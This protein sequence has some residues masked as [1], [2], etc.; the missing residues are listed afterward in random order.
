MFSD[1]ALKI[2]SAVRTG[3]IKTNAHF[4]KKFCSVDRI[5]SIKITTIN[6]EMFLKEN[7]WN[8]VCFFDDNFPKLNINLKNSEKPFLFAYKG[9]I[10]LLNSPNNIAVIGTTTLTEEISKRETEIVKEFVKNDLCI[11]SGLAKGCDTIAHEECLKNNGK[12]IAFLPTTLK[13]IYPKENKKL[14]EEIIKSG[15]LVI[16]EYVTEPKNKY[17]NIK[18]FIDRD[19]LQ[20]LFSKAVILVAS[21]SQGNGDSGSRHAMNKAKEYEKKQFVMFNEKDDNNPL[22]QMNKEY[23]NLGAK[24][25]TKKTIKELK[26]ETSC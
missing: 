12:T 11:V 25:L 16:T 23:I 9:N 14:A 5:N 26:S 19:R 22:F 17:E 21:N 1:I 18:R 15:G 13:D 2:F 3:I 10:E 20:A 24:V 7:D 4:F 6:E 8:L